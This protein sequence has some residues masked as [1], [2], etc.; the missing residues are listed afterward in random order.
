[1]RLLIGEG[2]AALGSI[3]NVL[4]RH[5]SPVTSMTTANLVAV[6]L[7]KIKMVPDSC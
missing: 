4:T 6:M 3:Y 5:E 7:I 1:M 2:R